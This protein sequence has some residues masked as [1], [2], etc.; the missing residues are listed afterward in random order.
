MAL[1]GYCHH[2]TIITSAVCQTAVR[3][4]TCKQAHIHIKPLVKF[5]EIQLCFEAFTYILTQ[6][7]LSNILLCVYVLP[8]ATTKEHY[9]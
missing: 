8:P 7:L 3:R 9:E 6:L 4:H 5:V 2:G 1:W